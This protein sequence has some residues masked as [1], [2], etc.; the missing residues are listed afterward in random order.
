MEMRMTSGILI[1][2]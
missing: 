1:W 2:R